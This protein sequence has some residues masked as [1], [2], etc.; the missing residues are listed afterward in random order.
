MLIFS[1]NISWSRGP[2]IGSDNFRGIDGLDD[3]FGEIGANILPFRPLPHHLLPLRHCRLHTLDFDFSLPN[4]FH[5][6]WEKAAL[7]LDYDVG[8]VFLQCWR[9]LQKSLHSTHHLDRQARC[10]YH[11]RHLHHQHQHFHHQACRHL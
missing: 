8:N 11:H 2:S 1:T 4:L 3:V 7:I 10:R 9:I 6:P 5:N